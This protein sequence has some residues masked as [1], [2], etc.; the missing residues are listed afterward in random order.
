[1]AAVEVDHIDFAVGVGDLRRVRPCPRVPAV[2]ARH[3]VEHLNPGAVVHEKLSVA[4]LAEG[5]FDEPPRVR[6]REPAHRLPR[7]ALVR[8]DEDASRRL[9]MRVGRRRALRGGGRLAPHRQQPL[10]GLRKD[11]ELVRN[12]FRHAPVARLRK[13]C[14]GRAP[15]HP[16]EAAAVAHVSAGREAERLRRVLLDARGAVRVKEPEDAFRVDVRRWRPHGP[17]L[18]V[19]AREPQ[20]LRRRPSTG[21]R[22]RAVRKGHLKVLVQCALNRTR[23]LPKHSPSPNRACGHA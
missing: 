17:T 11:V 12:D 5:A 8:A 18:P 7:V 9:F 20:H 21:A 16:V 1:M 3:F 19:R 6:R 4:H 10:P 22:H 2:V 23:R 15:R 13:D 14:G